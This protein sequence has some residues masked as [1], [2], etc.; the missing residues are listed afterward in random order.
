M[1]DLPLPTNLILGM[2]IDL[3]QTISVKLTIVELSY[4]RLGNDFMTLQCNESRKVNL[5]L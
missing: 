4:L 5:L 3:N 1:Y 2:I